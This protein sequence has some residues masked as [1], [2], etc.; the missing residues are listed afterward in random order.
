MHG[1]Q[2]FVRHY[3]CEVVFSLIIVLVLFSAA[4][5]AFLSY[6]YTFSHDHIHAALGQSIVRI[7]DA[8]MIGTQLLIPQEQGFYFVRK[9]PSQDN[10]DASLRQSGPLV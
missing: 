2:L 4:T 7:L 8:T 1:L 5:T 6:W 10:F 9:V 3:L